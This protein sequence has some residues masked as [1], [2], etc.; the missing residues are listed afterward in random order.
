M[1]WP[2]A[3]DA[4]QRLPTCERDWTGHEAV[5]RLT[6]EVASLQTGLRSREEPA[7][8]VEMR[9]KLSVPDFP[10]AV[11]RIGRSSQGLAFRF[12]AFP[13]FPIW[14]GHVKLDEVFGDYFAQTLATD[15]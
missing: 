1:Y 3:K 13:L 7:R 4:V 11:W 9:I 2:R 10:E 6:Q 15:T 14:C 8:Q 5:E 12:D